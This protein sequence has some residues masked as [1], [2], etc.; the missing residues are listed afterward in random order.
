MG[1]L[2]MRASCRLSMC[3]SV[4][5]CDASRLR[6]TALT[7]AGRSQNKQASIAHLLAAQICAGRSQRQ[8][9]RSEITALRYVRRTNA[10]GSTV[11]S[12]SP[13]PVMA[14]ER[15]KSFLW[16]SRMQICQT[17]GVLWLVVSIAQK[18]WECVPDWRREPWPTVMAIDCFV[19]MPTHYAC[20]LYSR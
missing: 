16:R 12:L 11:G 6:A 15:G 7:C 1:S 17:I 4:L 10:W 2:L 18:S 3:C 5:F 20:G 8:R 13:V 9:D 14:V 19:L